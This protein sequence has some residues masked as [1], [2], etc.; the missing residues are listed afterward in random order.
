MKRLVEHIKYLAVEVRM[1]VPM[2][3]DVLR[4]D[5]QN[6]IIDG[7]VAHTQEAVREWKGWHL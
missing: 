3:D 1:Q 7:Q 6:K 4:D 5:L 2:E